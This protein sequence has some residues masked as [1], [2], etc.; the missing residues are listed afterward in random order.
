MGNGRGDGRGTWGGTCGGGGLRGRDTATGR[1]CR[2]WQLATRTARASDSE[3]DFFLSYNVD[4]IIII[5]TIIIMIII[6]IIIYLAT[7]C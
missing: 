4:Y 2:D 7:P 6:I 3:P 5:I 1:D